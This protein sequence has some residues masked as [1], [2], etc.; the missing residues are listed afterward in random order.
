MDIVKVKLNIQGTGLIWLR[1][2]QVGD[3][4]ERG[5]KPSVRIEYGEILD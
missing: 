1:T 4:C 3:P 5:Y 2:G